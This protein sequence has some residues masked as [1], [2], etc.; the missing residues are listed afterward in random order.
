MFFYVVELLVLLEPGCEVELLGAHRP[1][2]ACGGVYAAGLRCNSACCQVDWHYAA[3]LYCS[4]AV[5]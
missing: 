3:G 1:P 5:C 2:R 4:P